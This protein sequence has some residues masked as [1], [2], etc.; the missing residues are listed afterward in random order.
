MIEEER[1]GKNKLIKFLKTYTPL[2][3]DEEAYNADFIEIDR[4]LSQGKGPDGRMQY[5]VKWKSMSYAD[6]TWE[7]Q[8]D[9]NVRLFFG[10]SPI[11]FA[12][13]KYSTLLEI[14]QLLGNFRT[15]NFL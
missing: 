2:E 8:E 5:L 14:S 3:D 15:D 9:I 11:F 7:F 1:M 12:C 10:K 6:S 4:I 13:Y